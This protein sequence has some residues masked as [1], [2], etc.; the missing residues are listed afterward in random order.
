MSALKMWEIKC[1]YQFC[2]SKVY[3]YADNLQEARTLPTLD[4]WSH[5]DKTRKDYCPTH[6][7]ALG[8]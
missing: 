8:Y 5:P 7:L 4:L 1:D 3:V 2:I 6:A